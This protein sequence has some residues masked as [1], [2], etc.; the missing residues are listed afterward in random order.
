MASCSSITV[1]TLPSAAGATT[2]RPRATASLRLPAARGQRVS[3]VV[4]CSAA[5]GGLGIPGKRELSVLKLV[6]IRLSFA[7]SLVT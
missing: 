6:R 4:R 2:S 5:P 1:V 3:G 7:I